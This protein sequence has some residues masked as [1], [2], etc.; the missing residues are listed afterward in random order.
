MQPIYP[1]TSNQLSPITVA[2][3]AWWCGVGSFICLPAWAL[4]GGG[5]SSVAVVDNDPMNL[6]SIPDEGQDI[7]VDIEKVGTVIDANLNFRDSNNSL[8]RLADLFDG[9]RP[10]MMSFN[11]SDCPKLCSVQLEN[12]VDALREVDFTI[13][14]DFDF[15]S[16]SIDPNEQASRA[17]EN[18]AKYLKRYNRPESSLGWNFWVGD[19]ESIANITGQTGFRFKY[20]REQK[21][22]SHPPVFILFSP[23]GKIVRYIHGLSYEPKTIKQ[24]LVEA[25]EGKIGSPINYLSYALGCFS[26]SNSTGQYHFQA[27][28]LMR[29]G[30][31]LTLVVLLIG[32]APYWFFRRQSK[33]GREMADSSSG[34]KVATVPLNHPTG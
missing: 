10:V 27:M 32:L 29:A 3:A 30:G 17:A 15:I 18:K 12:M 22:Y 13:G 21:L 8:V 11:Y 9:T 6:R 26:Y 28:F 31:L 33:E 34:L 16:I 19:R 5:A 7:G 1:K 23:E 20:V 25:A 2:L 4:D 14:Q 24:A